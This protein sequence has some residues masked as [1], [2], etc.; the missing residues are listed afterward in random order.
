MTSTGA[1]SG[2]QSSSKHYVEKELQRLQDLKAD[3]TW[4]EGKLEVQKTLI[5]SIQ[6]QMDN[7]SADLNEVTKLSASAKKRA[8]E[9][10]KVANARH[11]CTH[12]KTLTSITTDVADA[13]RKVESW[14]KMMRRGVITFV[15][16]LVLFGGALVVWLTLHNSVR[17]DVNILQTD[18][19][20]MQAD[21]STTKDT[22]TRIETKID[23]AQ[24]SSQGGILK[25]DLKDALSEV[26]KD[27]DVKKLLKK[28]KR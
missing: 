13:I 12:E 25:D 15:S 7:H 2:I 9:A 20:T 17:K 6:K 19:T 22:L 28:N 1:D 21:I 18:S 8:Y 10:E 3:K 11:A 14:D 23:T 26:L 27:P 16:A 4:V 5:V 24:A